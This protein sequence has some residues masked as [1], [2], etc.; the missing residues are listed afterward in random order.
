MEDKNCSN[1][2]YG[3]KVFAMPDVVCGFCG[4]V[5]QTDICEKY[6]LNMFNIASRG[7]RREKKYDAD[8]FKIE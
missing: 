1:C 5:S 4:I 6:Q 3:K 7:K 2:V 8:S